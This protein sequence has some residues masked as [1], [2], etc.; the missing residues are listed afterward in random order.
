MINNLVSN[1]LI[2]YYLSDMYELS[3]H[4]THT[5]RKRIDNKDRV[6]SN[7]LLVRCHLC[8]LKTA[9]WCSK[10]EDDVWL[11]KSNP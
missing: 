9:W 10:C 6:S 2:T 7:V 5:K 4:Q 1:P 3:I 11:E 8:R